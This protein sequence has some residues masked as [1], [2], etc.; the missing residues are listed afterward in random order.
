MPRLWTDTIEEH[1]DAVREALL[2]AVASLATEFGLTG[3]SMSAI[4]ARAGIGRATLYRYFPDLDAVLL[5]WH[6]RHVGMHLL[7]LAE[8]RDGHDDPYR[9]L[10]AVL[11]AYARIV[12]ESAR[13]QGHALFATLHKDRHVTHARQALRGLVQEIV[14]RGAAAGALRRDLPADEL[15]GFALAALGA[16]AGSSQA[17]SKRL[18][19]IVLAAF[20]P[21]R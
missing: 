14:A 7:A 11:Q 3:V 15:A 8:T 12:R 5:A 6:E 1:R 18:I 13:H 19:S 16:A 4:A 20:R 2:D 9:Q 21:L 17:G 10:E